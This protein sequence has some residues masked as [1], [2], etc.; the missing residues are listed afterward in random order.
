MSAVIAAL[1]SPKSDRPDFFSSYL[2]YTS[3]TEIPQFFSRWCAIAGIGAYLGRQFYFKH[4]HFTIHP[5]Q[6]CM[7]IGTPGTRKSVAI[8]IM[9][10]ILIGAGYDTIAAEKTTKEKFLMD[11]AGEISEHDQKGS[12]PDNFL[13]ANLFGASD[14]DAE[15]FIMADEFNDFFGNGNLEFISL[16]GS[17][18]DYNGIYRNRIKNGKSL[19][20]NNPT[21]SILGGNTPTGFSM[22]FPPEILGQ[23]FFSR[24]LLIYGAPNGKRITFPDS[25]DERVT[26]E[27]IKYLRT[28]KSNVFGSADIKR[29]ARNLLDKIYKT[30]RPHSDT[31]FESYGTRRFSHLLKL[32]LIIA[33]S[34]GSKEID[35]L[36]VIRANTVLTHTEFLMPKALGEFGKSKHSDV[37][38]KII[39]ILENAEGVMEFKNIWTHVSNDLDKMTDLS[40]LLQNMSAA[41]KIQMVPGGLG[42]LPRRIVREQLDSSIL[43]YSYLTQEEKDIAT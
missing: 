10:S 25:P 12:S 39:Q 40:T 18:W 17:L 41:D 23:G 42:F 30:T 5:N 20:I 14:Q 6:Y 38:H 36:D 21:V 7:L 24:I 8:K 13:D 4:G 31:R 15:V 33:A 9:K 22:A 16:L 34:R 32:T 11:L 1:P 28:I 29:E 3:E 43:D 19:A 26:A 27:L 37:T 35:E 2:P